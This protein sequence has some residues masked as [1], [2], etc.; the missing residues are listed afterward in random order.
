[1][2]SVANAK[3]TSDSEIPPTPVDTIFIDASSF[4]A[5]CNAALMA[6]EVPATSA[7]RI[8]LRIFLEPEPIFSNKLPRFSSRCFK[9][10]LSLIE[11]SLN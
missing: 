7:F 8:T 10:F 4:P 9:T 1:M 3:F 2:D 5:S 6:S 11:D